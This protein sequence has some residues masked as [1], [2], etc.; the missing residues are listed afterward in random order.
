MYEIKDEWDHF[1]QIFT[2]YSNFLVKKG[3]IRIQIRILIRSIIPN[4]MRPGQ[5]V[6]DPDLD[7]QHSSTTNFPQFLILYGDRF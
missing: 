5:K 3:K 7:P 4:T 1:E 2:K 6:P